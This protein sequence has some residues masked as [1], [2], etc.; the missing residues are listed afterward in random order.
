[1]LI[2]ESCKCV[3]GQS[4]ELCVQTCFVSDRFATVRLISMQPF[5]AS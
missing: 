3:D 5:A 1:M 2:A 4:A